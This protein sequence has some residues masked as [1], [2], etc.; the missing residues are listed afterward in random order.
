MADRIQ[1]AATDGDKGPSRI[2]NDRELTYHRGEEALYIGKVQNMPL[3]LCQ[4]SDIETIKTKLTANQVA[5]LSSLSS[6]ATLAQVVA[7]YNEL[8]SALKTSGVMKT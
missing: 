5:S 7:K 1:I 3:K 4:A 6:D 2:I 8:I